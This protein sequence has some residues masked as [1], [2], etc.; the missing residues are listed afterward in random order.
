MAEDH[1]TPDA[2]TLAEQLEEQTQRYA[3]LMQRIAATSDPDNLRMTI[4]EAASYIPM[5]E[6]QLAQLRYSGNGPS[7][8]K[9]TPRT[10]LYRKG[11][12]DEWLNNST[13]ITTATNT[14]EAEK[15]ARM[16]ADYKRDKQAA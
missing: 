4:A 12:L 5:N 1:G 11:D 10:I 3:A 15:R 9:P 7:F 6:G 16:I 8:L 14:E 13:Q 2:P